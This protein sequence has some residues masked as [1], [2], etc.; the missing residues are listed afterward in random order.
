MDSAADIIR[1]VVVIGVLLF[2]VVAPLLEF[3]FAV[4]VI[5]C[6]LCVA[7]LYS[8]DGSDDALVTMSVVFFG[9]AAYSVGVLWILDGGL[10][11]TK[12]WVASRIGS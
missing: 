5:N 8:L 3:E 9:Y 1:G 4:T 7:W 10:S 12:R 2:A 6:I 11:R